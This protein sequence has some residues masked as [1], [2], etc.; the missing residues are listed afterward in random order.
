MRKKLRAL[1]SAASCLTQDDLSEGVRRERLLFALVLPIEWYQAF[2][3]RR[4]E[5][6]RVYRGSD[7]GSSALLSRALIR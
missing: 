4:R 3:A 6:A 2:Q 7:A 1:E 5:L